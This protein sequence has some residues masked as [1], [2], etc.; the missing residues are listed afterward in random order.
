MRS[1]LAA[2]SVLTL[3]ALVASACSAA[4]SAGPP[5]HYPSS[6]HEEAIG[7]QAVHLVVDRTGPRAAERGAAAAVGRDEVAFSLALARALYGEAAKGSNVLASPLSADVALAMLEPGTRGATELAVA[8]ALQAGDLSTAASGDGWAGTLASFASDLGPVHLNIAD[9]V[10]LQDGVPFRQAYL[11]GI[12][13]DFGDAAYQANFAGDL[14]GAVAAIN[15]WVAAE[16]AGR[17]T[18]LFT[19]SSLGTDTIAVLANALHFKAAWDASL[20]FEA[21]STEPFHT[22]AGTTVP[23]PAMTA[24][25]GVDSETSPAETA[26]ELPYAGG[27]FSALILEP[28]GALAGYLSQLTPARLDSIVSSLRSEQVDLTLPSL[29]LSNDISLVRPLS[30]LG[31]ALAFAPNADLSG[32]SPEATHVNAVV[33]ANRLA[34]TAWG[35]DFASATGVGIAGSAGRLPS[36]PLVVDHPYLFMIRDDRTGTILATAVVGNPLASA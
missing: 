33:Q 10:W 29:S 2:A 34:V 26:I 17:I 14:P 7:N 6:V 25:A 15:Q 24:Q 35:T 12:A 28:T 4:P 5:T 31:M 23:V 13:R 18:K 19:P 20:A 1:R 21:G 32:I 9:S 30:A 27:R 36:P 3:L 16:T 11:S 8:R 22:S